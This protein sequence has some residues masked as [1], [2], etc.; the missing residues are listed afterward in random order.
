MKIRAKD[1]FYLNGKKYWTI[2]KV[3]EI[4]EITFL[5]KSAISYLESEWEIE[6]IICGLDIG[7]D[8]EKIEYIRNE[9]I[10]FHDKYYASFTVKQMLPKHTIFRKLNSIHG[11]EKKYCFYMTKTYNLRGKSGVVFKKEDV[12]LLA[13]LNHKDDSLEID[14]FIYKSQLYYTH[15]KVFEILEISNTRLVSMDIQKDWN[16][17]IIKTTYRDSGIS[18]S[19]RILYGYN[20]DDINCIIKEYKK[21]RET[22][23]IKFELEGKIPK[24]CMKNCLTSIKIDSKYNRYM[25]KTFPLGK[26]TCVYKKIEVDNIKN[27]I[28]NNYTREQLLDLFN[29]SPAGLRNLLKQYNIDFI[30]IGF[31]QFFSKEQVD[32]LIMKKNKYLEE[33]ST[34]AE[35]SEYFDDNIIPNSARKRIQRYDVPLYVYDRT[36]TL[37]L[38]QSDG[39]VKISEVIEIAKECS[40][41]KK[42]TKILELSGSNSYE[43]FILRLEAHP[44]WD[45]FKNETKYTNNKW[46]QFVQDYLNRT[47]QHE[48][49]LNGVITG[50]VCTSIAL[51]KMLYDSEKNEIYEMTTPE[52][53]FSLRNLTTQR[54][55]DTIYR[56]LKE[57]S[58][59]KH[60]KQFQ[61]KNIKYTTKNI[62]E[63]KYI[64][65]NEIYSIDDFFII[66]NYCTNVNL[67]I[68]KGLKEIEEKGT[69]KYISTWLY[70]CLHL[71][72]AWRCSD[73]VE[74]PVIDLSD[75]FLKND[76][77]NIDWFYENRVSTNLAKIV[78]SR[79]NQWEMII[80]KV[81]IKGAFFCSDEVSIP[82]ATSIMILLLY[83]DFKY[84]HQ[85]S[86]M[87]FNTKYNTPSKSMIKDFFKEITID[88][89]I[90]KS[91]K[92]NKSIMNYIYYLG[93][94]SGDA[95]SL[96]QCMYMRSHIIKQT[97]I[98]FYLQFDSNS[99]DELSKQ[100]F[101]RGEFGGVY[102]ILL[103]KINGNLRNFEEITEEI[104]DL[105][106]KFGGGTKMNLVLGFFNSLRKDREELFEEIKNMSLD[107]VQNLLTNIFL[108]KSPSKDSIDIQC[109]Y[110]ENNC[111][112]NSTISCFDCPYHIPTIYSLS[113]LGEK[114]L[115]NIEQIKNTNILPQKI[116]LFISLEKSKKILLEAINKFGKDIVYEN[117]GCDRN[118]F[119]KKLASTEN[120]LDK[121]LSLTDW[122]VGV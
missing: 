95:D 111:K 34:I 6:K 21:I 50:L 45:G 16:V 41:R 75:I 97:T 23:Y 49:R 40:E 107:E 60:K 114:I 29:I 109:I 105:N 99:I 55:R 81:H 51:Q 37:R 22:Y 36:N 122:E 32:D 100:L 15:K 112:K 88:N 116:K 59:D 12:D 30:K 117:L 83:R 1:E 89:F 78:I 64:I 54:D 42:Y 74:F 57:V 13:K 62:D 102:D 24:N 121:E 115:N 35:M 82:I 76:I 66:L 8:A 80:S 68:K 119:I 17:R 73:I 56:F 94:I 10:K 2:H 90:F 39:S 14:E 47:R 96:V 11:M 65:D 92:M 98:D 31:K 19:D 27:T 69:C 85:E 53:N 79:I 7:Y 72:N 38:K 113:L 91:Q 25:T 67:H 4:L 108:K 58:L 33:Y 120:A 5:K 3:E 61:I 71:N 48:K 106:H 86:I 46:F 110:H 103:K 20:A 44:D 87:I 101:K 52:I 9:V 70:V 84:I 18:A 26:S 118:E 104:D 77:T 28:E 93:I 43:T 63:E